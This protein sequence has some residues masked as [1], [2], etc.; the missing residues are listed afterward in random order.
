MRTVLFGTVAAAIL[1][2]SSSSYAAATQ[3]RPSGSPEVT[4][5]FTNTTHSC[6]PV[7]SA[8][9]G[10]P[11]GSFITFQLSDPSNVVAEFRIFVTTEHGKKDDQGPFSAHL[12]RDGK[13]IYLMP[14][15][16]NCAFA[17][18]ET[19]LG[20]RTEAFTAKYAWTMPIPI[21]GFNTSPGKIVSRTSTHAT[22]PT[23]NGHLRIPG[24]D[25]RV[26]YRSTR[27]VEALEQFTV[28]WIVAG[29]IDGKR[30]ILGD[31]N[32]FTVGPKANP[33]AALGDVQPPPLL[34]PYYE[35]GASSLGIRGVGWLNVFSVGTA[36]ASL[37]LIL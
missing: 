35:S 27:C 32:R 23:A 24:D 1:T 33:P 4:A 3:Q 7:S 15:S 17:T 14:G 12:E 2:A 20:A 10:V 29:V 36:L 26:M 31:L 16:I 34:T 6:V 11:V 22:I 37:Y 19:D 9:D 8:P 18:E 5:C 28:N 30:R 13:M 21:Y 25:N